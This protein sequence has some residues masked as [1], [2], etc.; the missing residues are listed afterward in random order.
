MTLDIG[1]TG[2]PVRAAQAATGPKPGYLEYL[3]GFRGLAILFVVMIHANNAMLQRGVER[4]EGAFSWIWTT[5]HILSHNSTVY[6]ALIS[7]VL[8]AYHL[9]SR[10]HGVFLRSRFEAVV[11]PYMLVSALLT[12]LFAGLDAVRGGQPPSAGAIVAQIAHNVLTGEAWNHLWYIPVIA[13][14]YVVSPLLMRA[15]ELP[16][17]GRPLA[18]TLVLLPLVFSRTGTEI[19]ISMLVYFAGVYTVGLLIGRDPEGVLARCSRRIGVIAMAALLSAGA[20][21]YLDLHGLDFV[22]PTSLR[23][24]AIYV[25]RISLAILGLVW[26]RANF[27]SLRPRARRTLNLIAAYS[28]GIYFLH[29][30]LLRPI[31]RVL[32]RFVPEGNPSWAL[33]AGIV[34]SFFASLLASMAI[35]RAIKRI[36]GSKSKFIIGS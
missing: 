6:F 19:T 31:V 25:L 36:A 22:G 23:E 28:F 11:V 13:I 5:F 2:A 34:V 16:R 10:P 17:V 20:V 12:L 8:Y 1:A 35:V 30:P 29:A 24:S 9:R 14:L 21:W 4:N 18:V 27:A 26:L 33:I 3:D 32:G 15:I 7:G